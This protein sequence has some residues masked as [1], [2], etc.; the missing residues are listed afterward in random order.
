MKT[1]ATLVLLT[2]AF[3]SFIVTAESAYIYDKDKGIWTRTG[4][5]NEYKVASKYPPGTKLS[6]VNP[7]ANNGYTQIIDNRGRKSWIPSNMLLETANVSLDKARAEIAKLQNDHKQEVKRLQ[8]E[9]SARA[10][11]EK[12]NESLQSK[13]SRMQIELE[14]LTQEN[15]AMSHRF[16]RE[17]YFAGGVTVLVGMLFG[18][19][20]GLRGRKRDG[21]WS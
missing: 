7:V 15:S 17:I 16:N 14:Q 8:A 19:I 13:I 6:I 12:M 21:A 3:A 18:W 9:L 10:P 5:S 2:L 1:I 4:P 11:L 20:F